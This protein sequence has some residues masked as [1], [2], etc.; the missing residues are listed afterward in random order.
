MK[1]SGLLPTTVDQVPHGPHTTKDNINLGAT[2]LG[3]REA[4]VVYNKAPYSTPPPDPEILRP[5]CLTFFISTSLTGTSLGL[6]LLRHTAVGAML[7]W[8]PPQDC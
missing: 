5:G 4:K 1:V 3:G 2:W 6:S 7:E 8:R